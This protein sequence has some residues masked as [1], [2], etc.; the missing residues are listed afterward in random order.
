MNARQLAATLEAR[1]EV[2][3]L[4]PLNENYDP[5]QP[6]RCITLQPHSCSGEVVGAVGSIP[7]CASGVDAEQSYRRVE[8]RRQAIWENENADLLA[9]EAAAEQAFERRYA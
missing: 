9:R 1:I 3:P 6:W 2:R 5:P 4:S 8:A 7:V